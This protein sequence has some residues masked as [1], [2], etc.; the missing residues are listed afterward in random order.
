MK[1]NYTTIFA[2]ALAAGTLLCPVAVH[3]Q[4]QSSATDPMPEYVRS[5]LYTILVNSDQQN[6]RL[7]DE[8]LYYQVAGVEKARKGLDAFKTGG[9]VGGMNQLLLGG[10]ARADAMSQFQMPQMSRE[11]YDKMTKEREKAAKKL[12]K[13]IKKDKKYT[14][15]EKASML[16]ALDAPIPTYDEYEQTRQEME[17]ERQELVRELR[18]E[19][20]LLAAIPGQQFP[21]IPIPNQFNDHCLTARILA[22][23]S[24]MPL[25]TQENWDKW[26]DK[27]YKENKLRTKAKELSEK[28]TGRRSTMFFMDSVNRTLPVV[29]GRYIADN[30]VGDEMLAK[31][32]G[33]QADNAQHWDSLFTLIQERGLQNASASDIARARANSNEWARLAARG[34]DMVDNTY[35]AAVNLAFRSNQAVV[36]ENQAIAK[37]AKEAAGNVA[38][39]AGKVSRWGKIA[40]FGKFIPGAG[41]LSDAA[42]I[43]GD[44]AGVVEKS[45]NA[46]ESATD[47]A[48]SDLAGLA[49]GAAA[50]EGFRVTAKIY[51]YKLGWNDQA[52][53]RFAQEVFAQNGSLADLVAKDIVELNLVGVEDASALVRQSVFNE[54]PKTELVKRATG[55]AIDR[56]IAKLQQN[57]EE[58]R[59]VTPISS[60]DASGAILAKIGLKEGIVEGD[61]Y[62]ILEPVEDA[63]G[64]ITYRSKGTVSP[65]KTQIWNNLY[66]A[67][68]QAAENAS[69]GAT[70]AE[71]QAVKFGYTRFTGASAQ[72]G[73]LLRLKSKAKK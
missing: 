69:A 23:D 41:A 33:Y 4:D 44:V 13:D 1:F 25:L 56:T 63:Q 40:K 62:E 32:F 17:K 47:F 46:V 42:G 19:G 48:S 27:N 43:A 7:D 30:N 16:Q 70:T 6:Q 73:Y 58:F 45:A 24:I 26:A 18:P 52:A 2:L 68:L 8:A 54:N 21:T 72:P 39:T 61:E 65:D 11:D 57:H 20:Q 38:E 34:F 51:L 59:P 15:E 29:L 67:D 5:S 14:E 64:R 31:W 66:E 71:D 22:Y 55:R 9:V 36:A 49:A 28:A 12:A 10:S 37:A 50:G 53:D 3:S 60:V 35:F